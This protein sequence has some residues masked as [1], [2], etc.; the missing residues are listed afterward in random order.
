MQYV[1]CLFIAK[2]GRRFYQAVSEFAAKN[3]AL[4]IVSNVNALGET[5]LVGLKAAYTVAE[6]FRQHRDN[7]ARQIGAVA[8]YLSFFIQRRIHFD[9]GTDIGNMNAENPVA[10]RV[11]AK[12][13]CVVE[14]FCVLRVNCNNYIAGNIVARVF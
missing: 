2:T 11:L 5:F 1:I 9:K 14:V 8:A 10:V 3:I 12:T 7:F 13:Y 6:N 4:F